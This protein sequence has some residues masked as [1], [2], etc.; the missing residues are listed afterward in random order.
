MQML[1]KTVLLR[2]HYD[3]LQRLCWQCIKSHKENEYYSHA[4]KCLKQIYEKLNTLSNGEH[5]N[6]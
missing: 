4:F 2:N 3:A 6:E 5:K 1:Y